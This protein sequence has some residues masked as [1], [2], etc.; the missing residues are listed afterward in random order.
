LRYFLEITIA[1]KPLIR[2]Y[3]KWRIF[4]RIIKVIAEK[5]QKRPEAYTLSLW[6]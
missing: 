4:L 6:G 1:A 3:Y 2:E 5:E